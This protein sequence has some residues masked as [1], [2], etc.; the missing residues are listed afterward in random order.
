MKVDVTE[1][2]REL[3]LCPSCPTYDVCMGGASETLFCG[4]GETSCDPAS[5]GC[6]CGGCPVTSAYEL[7]G[8]YYCLAGTA[9]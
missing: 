5:K 6:L 8:G 1:Q 3:C 7:S 2:N 4:V 9:D